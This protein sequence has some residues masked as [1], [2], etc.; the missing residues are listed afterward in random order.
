VS[1]ETLL[2][3]AFAR[4]DRMV[5]RRIADEFILVPLVSRGAEVDCIYNLNAV[6]A[7][8]WERL[9]GRTNGATIVD[10]LVERFDVDRE[11]VIADYSTF[12]EKLRSIRAIVGEDPRA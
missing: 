7:F 12:L 9:D 8:I 10:A 4:S 6:G 3:K 1:E 2:R 11:R 5:G